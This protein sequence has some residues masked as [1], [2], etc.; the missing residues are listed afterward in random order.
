MT[1]A[2]AEC[3]TTSSTNAA[4]LAGKLISSAIQGNSRTLIS[5]LAQQLALGIAEVS[6]GE[7]LF[8]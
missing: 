3:P 8:A 1:F 5:G 7:L 6:A 4:G 2:G